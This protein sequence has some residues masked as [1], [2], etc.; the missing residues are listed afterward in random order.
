M[1][2]KRLINTGGGVACTTDTVQI[3]DAGTT[4]SVALYRFED[5]ADDTS[6]STG[7]FGKGAVF[8]GTSSYI[9]LPANLAPAI[10][11]AAAFSV[12]LWFQRNG[13]QPNSYGG[14]LI[15]ILN[16]IYININLETNNTVKALVVT[17]TPAYPETVTGVV[18]DNTWNHIVFAGNNNGIKLYLNGS[19]AD[20]DT[21]DG[22]FMTYTNANYK[23]NRIGYSGSSVAYFKGKIDQVRFFDRALTS[24]EVTTLYS[25]TSSTVN[26]LQILGDTSCIAA[27][28]F[29]GNANDLSTNY[30]GTASNVI[31]DYSGTASSS[32]T[33]AAGKFD[34][35]AVFDGSSSII[36]LGSSSPLNT[37]GGEQTISLWIYPT[38]STHQE[39]IGY[40][41]DTTLQWNYVEKMSNNTIRFLLRSSA[42]PLTVFNT[43][44]TVTINQWNHI[45]VTVNSTTAKIYINNGTAESLASTVTSFS[46]SE[47]T[48]IGEYDALQGVN[49]FNGKI[50]QI[51]IFDKSLSSGEVNSLYN[52]TATSAASATIDNPSTIAYY[53]MADA[54]D[55]TGSYNG[56]ATNVDFNVQGKYGFAGKF[57]G[58][59]SKIALSKAPFISLKN[60]FS[61]SLWFNSNVTSMGTLFSHLGNNTPKYGVFLNHS[62]DTSQSIRFFYSK[63]S[64]SQGSQSSSTNIWNL[65]QW[66]HL[67][68]TKSSTDGL[69]GYLDNTQIITDATLTDDLT[70]YTSQNGN[71]N[72]GI[73]QYLTSGGELYPFNGKIDQVR[74]F[75]KAISAAEV[76]KL[77]NEIQ[78][79]NTITT[80]ES[81]FNTK[82]YTGNGGTQPLTGVGFAPGMTWIKARSVGYSHL[83]QDTLRGPGTSTSLY[84]DLNSTEGTYGAYGQISAFG[85]DGFTV[86]SGGHATYPTA[87]V[88]QNGV[89]YASWN[90]KAASSNTTNNNGTIP[91]TVRASQESGF[92][93]GTYT[94]NSTAGATIGHGLNSTPELVIVKLRSGISAKAW[95]VYAE[96]LGNTKYLYLDYDIVAGTYNFWND[97]SPTSSV[98][99]LS[100]DTNVNS[101]SGNYVFYAFHSVDG[102]Q[103][104][105]SY[106]GNGSANGPFI[107]TGFEPAWVIIKNTDTPYRWYM[108]DNKRDTTNPNGARLFAEASTAEATN[109]NILNFHTNGFELITS[110]AEVNK[111]GDTMLF[112]AI[113]A[114]PDTTAPTKANSFKTVIYTGD[115][116]TSRQVTGVGFKP[117][118]TWIKQRNASDNHALFD[119]VR[120]VNLSL[121]SNLQNSTND[122][123]DD[124]TKGVTSFDDDGF[125]LGSWDN[126]NANNDTY[127]AWLWKA[128]DHDRNLPAINN[129]GQITAS[130]SANPA[131]GFSIVKYKGNNTD[132]ATVGHGLDVAPN[133][134][135]VKELGSNYWC[136]G[137]STVGDGENLYLNV[138]TARQTRDRIKSVQT[139]TFTLGSHFEVNSTDDYVAYCFASKSG[140]S[141]IDTYEGTNSTVTVSN[142]GFKPSFVMIKNVDDTGNWVMLDNTRNTIT[143]RL[144]NW[145]RADTSDQETGAVSTAYIT[146][147]DDGFIVANTTSL[148]TNSNGDTYL[149]MAFK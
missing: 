95:T 65:G 127:V 23:F 37:F 82:L 122:R 10:R 56:T 33:Y 86:A 76:T 24:N 63:G 138:N 121:S 119:S 25:E 68:I 26:T 21:W 93:M 94:G 129:N 137:G 128:L 43:T 117:D 45:V 31:Y 14:R 13:N 113:A 42:S 78:C 71:S 103:R 51:R 30:N 17:S 91:S 49:Y 15:Q 38:T 69:K 81:Y 74:I 12:S 136:V 7:K 52:E 9:D 66:H 85:T 90:W 32:V 145:L 109:S 73:Y 46:N 22:T 62:S 132:N 40:R 87:Q 84:P 53:K 20:S 130:V 6:N 3:L 67:V 39:I 141:K 116:G 36:D 147:N 61:Y 107:Y 58:S 29:E 28:T 54:T 100:T 35:A 135:I 80:P 18:P 8:N 105:G 148:G 133:I 11:S 140:V 16:D 111:D 79:A 108:L 48:K 55:E 59:N 104:I 110:D 149:Y 143:D 123:N 1:L 118:L 114:N 44:G 131:F 19:L 126:V 75:N 4:D 99:S 98:I 102:Y 70:P 106:V 115:G 5:N 146:V 50:D 57:N 72:I 134:V 88:N 47:S 96:P 64:N 124:S 125:T 77:Y 112:M 120:G 2:G 144:N 139:N 34:K 83:L 101:S 27:Y 97:T 92:S 142:V 60:N 41:N 89:T